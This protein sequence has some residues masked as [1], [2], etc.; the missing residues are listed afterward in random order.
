MQ[1]ST[2]MTKKL[3]GLTIAILLLNLRPGSLSQGANHA[4]LRTATDA[5]NDGD[6]VT[7]LRVYIRLLNSPAGDQF[8]EPIALQIGELFQTEEITTDGRAPRLSPDGKL[9]AYETGASSSVMTRMVQTVGD[10]TVVTELPGTGAVFSPSGRKVAYIKPQHNEEIAKAQ[11]ALDS[12]PAGLA[13]VAA[14]LTVNRLLMKY[15][16]VML[17]DLDTQQETEL[18]TGDLL[19]STLAFGA[20]GETIYVVAAREGDT[21]RNDIYA[22]TVSSAQP[23]VLTDAEGFKTSPVVDPRGRVLLFSIPNRNPFPPPPATR[24]AD[25][26]ASQTEGGGQRFQGGG[27]ATRF[28]IVDLASRKVTVV[29]GTAFTLSA[30]GASAAYVTRTGQEN[31]LMHLPIGGNPATL[32]K[33]TDRLDAP[34]FSPDGQRLAYQKM[35][36]D[37]WEVFLIKSDGSGETR[38][39]REIQHDVLPR[40]I[41]QDRLLAMIGEPRHRRSY[42]YDLTSLT[43]IRLFHNNTVRTIAP[44]YGWSVA[45]D[46]SKVLIWAERDG[47][48]VSPERGVYLVHLDRKITK[49]DLLARLEKNLAAEIAL[50]DQAQKM[51]APIAEEVR[52]VVALASVNRIYE[53]EKALFDFDSKNISRPGNRKASEY[54]YQTYKSFGYEPEYQWFEPRG[55]FEGKTA[56]VIATLRGTEHP[57]LV[58]VVSSHYDSVTAGPGADDDT[59][60][61]AALLEAARIMAGK[62]MP[63]TIIFASFTGEEAG[64]S[65]SREFVRRAQADKTKIAGVLNNDMIGWTNDGRLDN[66]IRYT[67]AGIRDIQHAA[68]MLFTRLITYDARYH[69]STDATAFYEAYGDIVGG[70]GSYPVLGNPHYHMATDS[71]DTINHQLVTETCKTTVATLM[72]LASSPS[73][74][75]DLRVVSYDGTTAELAWTPSPEKSVRAYIVTYG[76]Q[77]VKVVTPKVTLRGVQPGTVVAVKAVNARG[78]EGWDWA[79]TT[80]AQKP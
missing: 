75:K 11:A 63:A 54:L 7:A 28:G 25:E 34:A 6:Y 40:F 13:R 32:L 60:G 38:L 42:L 29:A 58:Y 27:P 59:S 45:P 78:L 3:V 52:R 31:S 19:K 71:L 53:Y 72:L 2:A 21:S 76:P 18:P 1:H 5:W 17:R 24:Q 69:R 26:A 49:A 35:T 77:R 41:G 66:T 67:N 37:N 64:L 43:R 80:I 62:P 47:D 9:M 10:H 70:I 20:D 12:A 14:Q 22:V 50:R 33:T 44:E 65:G 39:T 51:Y 74:V 8:L 68:A 30:D 56:N 46:G 79:R 55:A 23:I 48:T 36:R 61:T 73:P 16:Q 15:S 57:E 4:D